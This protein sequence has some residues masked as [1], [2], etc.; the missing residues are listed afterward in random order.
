M[1]VAIW[2]SLKAVWS[3]IISLIG[4]PEREPIRQFNS[5]VEVAEY[6]DKHFIYTGDPF[7][8]A[9]DFYI[10][11]EIMQAAFNA[12]RESTSKLSL[13]CDDCAVYAYV[14]L[15]TI[16]GCRPLLYTIYDSSGNWGHHVICAFK[17]G[18]EYGVIDTNGLNPLLS[19]NTK[20]ICELFT[21]IYKSRGYVYTSCIYT[22]FPFR[23]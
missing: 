18:E 10:H 23:M 5:P 4:Y 21:N 19:L 3:T 9:G 16:P 14:A 1:L 17:F 15:K 11:P 6:L 12:G 13:D 20:I 22:P 7:N 2:N 8:G